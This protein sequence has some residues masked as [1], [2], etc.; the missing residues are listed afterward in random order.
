[1][2]VNSSPGLEGIE[3]AT[4]KDVAAMVYQFLEKPPAAAPHPRQWLNNIKESMQSRVLEIA[5]VS[6]QPGETRKIDLPVG[7]LYTDASVA[8]P[9][10]VKRGRRAGPTLFISAAVH[11]DELNGI[12]IIQRL[13]ASKALN[14][15]ARYPYRRAGGEC[16]RGDQ[17]QPLPARP[18]RFKPLIPRQ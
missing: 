5:G 11:G 6:I 13:I 18:P 7:R 12:A 3:S 10:Y 8:M 1:M 16:V 9:I 2:E 4:G 14:S 15:P 17:P